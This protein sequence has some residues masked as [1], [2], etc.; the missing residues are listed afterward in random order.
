MSAS[1]AFEVE[2]QELY[3]AWHAPE[4]LITELAAPFFEARF[5]DK[6]WAIFTP[7]RSAAWDGHELT[8]GP[9]VP[10][11]EF[12]HKD[13]FDDVWKTYYKSIF[14]PARLK[15]KAMRAE[16]S[17]KYWASMPE[18]SLI[19]E[20][21]REAPARLQRMAKNANVKAEPPVGASLSEL[22]TAAASCTACP[23]YE[24][25]TQTVFGEGPADAGIMIVGEQPGDQEDLQGRAFVGPAGEV[26][27]RALAE[28]G[29]SR[30]SIYLTNAVK[31][32]KWTRQGKRRL[33]QKPNGGEM[34]ACRPWLESEIARVKPRVILALG[35][36]AGTSIL[37]RLP[38]IGQ[39]R[40]QVRTDSSLARAIVVSWHPSAI[41][42]SMD[43]R[44]K[45]ERFDQLVADLKIVAAAADRDARE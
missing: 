25:A 6:P 35:A 30:D 16:M 20:L 33:H 43:E 18:A 41:L 5:G 40:G 14:N 4:H 8:Y 11:H 12:P 39:E 28:A 37:G 2:G 27:N 9:G 29:L 15:L 13:E 17:P 31:H 45:K 36:T 32:F 42:R 10:Q 19:P 44:E 26:F 34:H 23:L 7:D 1:S 22:K 38:K 21:I 24:N 3:V